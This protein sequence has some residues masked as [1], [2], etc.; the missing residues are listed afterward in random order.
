[1][2]VVIEMV[3]VD[4]E[5]ITATTVRDLWPVYRCCQVAI[6]AAAVMD[7]VLLLP[8]YSLTGRTIKNLL[9]A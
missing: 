9:S 4:T 2:V 6:A 5:M 1:M 8:Y 3:T 7:K